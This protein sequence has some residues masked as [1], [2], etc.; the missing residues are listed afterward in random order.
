VAVQ[1]AAPNR[2]DALSTGAK[3]STVNLIS[4]DL[5]QN[6][7]GHLRDSASTDTDPEVSELLPSAAPDVEGLVNRVP[8]TIDALFL[9][10]EQLA[11]QKI[12][13][14]GGAIQ[15][16]EG[17]SA[18]LT[19]IVNGMGDEFFSG[20]GFA[21]DKDRRVCGSNLLHLSEDRFESSATTYDALERSLDLISRDSVRDCCTI[22][23]R[24]TSTQRSTRP[25]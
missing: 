10:T 14:D 2:G 12:E 8:N 4:G 9:V 11:F 24:N 13:R 19:C 15:V 22:S 16:D 17:T 3:G 6:F 21:L 25:R 23:H 20:A 7:R 5:A 18:A 1:D